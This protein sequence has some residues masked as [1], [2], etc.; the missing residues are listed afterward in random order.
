MIAL[1]VIS[2]DGIDCGKSHNAG[3]LVKQAVATDANGCNGVRG[4]VSSGADCATMTDLKACGRHVTLTEA[5]A[6]S[7]VV[8]SC[9][10]YSFK[11][12]DYTGR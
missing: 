8:D 11:V 3:D 5:I 2:C 12:F 4:T 9:G 10:G 1:I 7:I 6:A